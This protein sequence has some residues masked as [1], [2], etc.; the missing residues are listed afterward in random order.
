MIDL[1]KV[2]KKSLFEYYPEKYKE[3]IYKI[4]KS[5]EI[6]NFEYYELI[7][8]LWGENYDNYTGKVMDYNEKLIL[9][10]FKNKITRYIKEL[11]N[12]SFR[13]FTGFNIPEF[14]NDIVQID[15]NHSKNGQRVK[16]SFLDYFNTEDKT[17]ILKMVDLFKIYYPDY[18]F[19]INYYY[20]GDEYQI[21]KNW[22]IYNTKIAALFNSARIKINKAL[23]KIK[24]LE[25]YNLEKIIAVR[26]ASKFYFEDNN[27]ELY[28]EIIDDLE[29][30]KVKKYGK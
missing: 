12:G 22:V 2:R 29:N 3:F 16:E 13:G 20:Y 18:Y 6:T 26:N 21:K 5:F 11:E 28:K 30:A 10:A 15:Y 27:D 8:A 4:I 9:I 14:S 23:E 17:I 7:V 1:Y 25:N 24:T 19:A